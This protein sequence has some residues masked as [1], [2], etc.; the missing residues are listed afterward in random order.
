LKF[1][2]VML[3]LFYFQLRVLVLLPTAGAGPLAA[4]IPY[5]V[6][7][8]RAAAGAFCDW[9]FFNNAAASSALALAACAS[10][11][12]LSLAASCADG[13]NALAA[14]AS[15]LLATASCDALIS[16]CLFAIAGVAVAVAVVAGF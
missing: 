1:F 6:T 16:A 12:S 10:A 8:V 5:V 13:C 3:L 11:L 2:L 15:A 14:A 9:Y 7:P 4:F